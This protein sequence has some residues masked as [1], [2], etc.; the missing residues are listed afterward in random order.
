MRPWTSAP[1]GCGK[2]EDARAGGRPPRQVIRDCHDEQPDWSR[3]EDVDLSIE[4]LGKI[5]ARV[6]RDGDL[7]NGALARGDIGVATTTNAVRTAWPKRK[8]AG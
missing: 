3:P 4:K 6:E 1:S 5:A 8:M 2:V 7:R